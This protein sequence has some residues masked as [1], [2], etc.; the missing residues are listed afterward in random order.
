MLD[1]GEIRE[2]DE[3]GYRMRVWFFVAGVFILVPVV[4]HFLLVAFDERKLIY[5][6]RNRPIEHAFTMLL[7]LWPPMIVS[8]LFIRKIAAP[9]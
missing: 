3:D 9:R 8:L 2:I 7:W 1:R 4:T 5:D 6:F